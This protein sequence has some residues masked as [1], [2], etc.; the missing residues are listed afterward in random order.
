M[1]PQVFKAMNPWFCEKFGNPSS[2]YKLGQEARAAVDKARKQVAEHLN[3]K[4]TEVL[5]T[6]SATESCNWA[7]FGIV[8]NQL[9]KGRHAHLII[10]S[11]EHPAVRESAKF[12]KKAYGVQL[13]ELPVNSDGVISLRDLENAIKEETVLVSIMAISNEIGSI[14]PIE[15]IGKICREKKVLFHT[16]ACQAAN[17]IELDVSKSYINLLSLNGSKIYGPKGI[18]VLYLQDGVELSPWTFGGSQEFGMRAGTENVPCIVGMGKA[19]ELLD[20]NGS[21]INDLKK[22]RDFC[23]QLIE[24]KIDKVSL[25][26]SL[27]NRSP[28]NLNIFIKGVSGTTLVQ[29]MDL[30]GF[31]IST[32]SAC[33]SA[34]CNPSHVLMSI[35]LNPRDCLSSIRISIGKW[36]KKEDLESFVEKLAEIVK[37]LRK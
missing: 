8:E 15:E 14:Q 19:V 22:L 10:S 23:L 37:E 13:T 11:I 1:D 4:P 33:S 2:V 31:A 30:E 26:G 24:K 21:D 29:R 16:D 18:G 27:E 35:G 25:N 12:L 6:S 36:T 5:F 28:I 3:C 7:L 17:Y 9:L 32:A 34:L 20:K